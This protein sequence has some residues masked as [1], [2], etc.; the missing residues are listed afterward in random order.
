[1]RHRTLRSASFLSLFSPLFSALFEVRNFSN[2]QYFIHYSVGTG[3]RYAIAYRF[4]SFSVQ[5]IN[6]AF[7]EIK[8]NVFRVFIILVD[9]YRFQA[10]WV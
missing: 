1:M 10:R 3:C 2:S 9:L 7:N 5:V 4:T 8:L 6:N